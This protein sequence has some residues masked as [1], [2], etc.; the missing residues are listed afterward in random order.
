M[1]K[2]V[3]VGAVGPPRRWGTFALGPSLRAD[4]LPRPKEHSVWLR[5]SEMQRLTDGTVPSS[6][7]T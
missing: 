1:G 2:E 7:R 4:G 6:S 5:C 3:V